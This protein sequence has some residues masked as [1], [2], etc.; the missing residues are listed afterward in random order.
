VHAAEFC[1]NT[2]AVAVSALYVPF[3][4]ELPAGGRLLGADC[5]S[6]RDS[7]L[8]RH[9]RFSMPLF[10]RAPKANQRVLKVFAAQISNGH[11]PRKFAVEHI[12]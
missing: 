1:E 7:G 6:G 9:R 12:F 4:R 10:V 5:G 11:T 2:I 3:L 8:C